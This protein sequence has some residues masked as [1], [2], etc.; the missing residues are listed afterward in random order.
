MMQFSAV[1]FPYLYCNHA[2]Q[3]NFGAI[4]S[5]NSKYQRSHPHIKIVPR[6]HYKNQH[7]WRT[8]RSKT[9]RLY[10]SRSDGCIAITTTSEA[11]MMAKAT[12]AT[13]VMV[14]RL[15]GNLPCMTQCWD[16]K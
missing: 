16:W 12:K 4:S 5:K 1:Q 10:N 7:P 15:A 13:M 2:A 14:P 11:T 9:P 6:D 3:K 8:R